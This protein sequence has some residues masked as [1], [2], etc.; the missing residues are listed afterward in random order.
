[1][2]S[3]RSRNSIGDYKMNKNADMRLSNYN[4]YEHSAYGSPTQK[5]FAAS[6]NTI[7]NRNFLPSHNS[8]DVESYL[9][10]INSSNMENDIKRMPPIIQPISYNE[11][12]FFQRPDNI[13]PELFTH[14][15]QRP[16]I[17]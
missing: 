17:L 15:N 14:N 8:I 9:R 5:Q 3:T 10:G 11:I 1:M 12:S 6:G 7:A 2:A 4:L 13:M 16:T